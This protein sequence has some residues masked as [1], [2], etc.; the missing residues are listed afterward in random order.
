MNPKHAERVIC[1]VFF[2]SGCAALVFETLWFRVAATVLGSSVWSATAVLSA[3]MGGLAIGNGLMARFGHRVKNPLSF[4]LMVEVAIGLSGLMVI[5][6]LPKLSPLIGATLESLSEQNSQG[7]HLARFLIAAAFLTLP[8]IA[9]GT[10]LPVMQKLLFHIDASFMRTIA[11]L[12]GWNTVGAVSGVLLAEF[13]LI[14]AIG[15][16]GS[17]AV[18]LSLN[19]LVIFILVR[20]FGKASNILP[21]SPAQTETQTARTPGI[22]RLL[23]ATALAGFLLLALEVLWFRYLLLSHSGTSQAFAMMLVVVLISIALGGMLMSRLK[24][25]STQVDTCLSVLPLCLAFSVMGGLFAWHA[26]FESHITEISISLLYFTCLALLLIFPTA[27]LSGMLFPLIGDAVFRKSGSTTYSSGALTMANTIGAAL[28]A[29]AASFYLIPAHGIELSL[30]L[31]ALVYVLAGFCLA[32]RLKT[33][34]ASAI[35]TACVVWVLFPFGAM[36]ASYKYSTGRLFPDNRLLHFH[37]GLYETLGYFSND[38][39]GE[40]LDIRL[41]TNHH[42]MTGTSYASRRYMYMFA[43]FPLMFNDNIQDVLQISYGI[44]NTADAITR[45]PKLKNLDIVDLSADI[46]EHSQVVHEHTGSYPLRDPRVRTHIEDGRFYLQATRKKYDLIT[47]EPPPPKH[48][49]VVN[50]YTKEYFQLVKDALADGGM[51]TYWLPL[52][53]IEG[54]DALAIIR[55]F[56]DVFDDCSMW[57]GTGLDF[58]LV[59]SKNG[60]A[61]LNSMTLAARW[62]AEMASLFS[63]IAFNSPGEVIASFLGGP[64]SLKELTRHVL[65]VTDDFPHRIR[66]DYSNYD[67]SHALYSQLLNI[68]RRKKDFSNSAYITRLM[69]APLRTASLQDF[70]REGL[71]TML[72]MPDYHAALVSPDF[73][74][75][76]NI[77]NL[78]Q[79]AP[80]KHDLALLL[81]ANPDSLAILERHINKLVVDPAHRSEYFRLLLLRQEHALLEQFTTRFMQTAT[82]SSEEKSGVYRYYLLSRQSRDVL[83]KDDLDVIGQYGLDAFNRDF[84]QWVKARTLSETSRE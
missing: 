53:T 17:A 41:I 69:D 65:P 63:D 23:C 50:L 51:T 16:K 66:P 67:P 7:L 73:A 59:G 46:F 20:T 47:G 80:E 31:V 54:N 2:L 44:G 56:C 40:I 77:V 15:I 62:P 71:I 29:S 48:A 43:Y 52:H 60:M 10:T 34:A 72:F 21:D 81:G 55:A 8:A 79:Q 36:Q 14:T 30:C 12:Y 78:M 61:P 76:Q 70:T 6:I 35:A 64:E 28:G 19:F 57:N 82:I 49:G 26:F 32:T 5:L 38:S 3:F 24:L 27:F 68:E 11:L 22:T 18:A 83:S 75:W 39:F 9:M 45:L 84:Y 25:T 13:I 42:S 58:M 1:C 37:E 33:Y 4:Y 74:Y